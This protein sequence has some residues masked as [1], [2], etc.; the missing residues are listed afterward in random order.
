MYYSLFGHN[1]SYVNKGGYAVCTSLFK[2]P[3]YDIKS[4]FKQENE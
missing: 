2:K 3:Q 4:Y 1:L